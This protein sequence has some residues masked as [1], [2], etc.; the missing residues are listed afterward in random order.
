M[1]I[2]Q[3]PD[4]LINQI[5]AGE[6][7]ER[8]AS[9]VKELVENAL[10]AGATRVDI[11]LEEGGVRLIRIRDNGG[12]IP[13]DELP[14]AVSRHATS[15]IASLDD[16]ETVATL[17]FR[18]EALPS[19][20]S[21]SRFTLV[22]RRHDAEHGSAL[23]IEGGRLGEVTPRAHAPGTTVE[24]RELFYN[25]PARRK[26]L[27]AERT[28][29]GHIEEWLRSLA[30][31]RPDV[32]LRVSHN[33]KPSR[34]YKPGD[35]Y[36]DARL[37]E[38]LGEDFARQALRVD[39]GGAGLRL[40][41]WVAQPHYSRAS[42]DQQYL[43]VNGRSVRDRSVAHA[44]KM[45]Y[46]D[47][48]FHGRQPAYVLFL[49]LDPA[50][51]DVNVH[52]AK[53]EVRFREARLI[54]DFVYRTLQDALAHTRAGAMPNSIGTEG[55]S[56]TG[57]APSGMANTP[58]Y[59]GATGSG[60]G[61]GYGNWTPSQT[62]LGLRV[63]EARAAYSALYAPPSGSAQQQ[64]A[65]MQ[66][67]SGTGL[68]ATSHDSGVPPLG[69]AVAQLHGIY[70]LAENAEGLIVVDMH[71]A[72]ERIGYERLK[73]AHDSIGL[74][75][76]PLLVP[77]TLAVG[78]READTAEREADTLASLGF[79]ITRAG[80]QSLHVR[81]IPALL[82]NA[83]PEALLRDVL[84]D[85]REH[86]QSRRIATARDELLSTMA[87]HGAVRANRRLTVPE[88][89]ALLRDMEATERSGQCNH[90][91]PTWARVT[92]GEIDRWFLR[93]R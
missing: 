82:A 7:V 46:G 69:Y 66:T 26:F 40:H 58:N 23:E 47:V 9:V 37:G 80:P 75:A 29:L 72:H 19:I 34:R 65:A 41:G 22:S 86:G 52:P 56:D 44:V 6:V 89:N 54:H 64:S 5:A 81:S 84:G 36:S 30:L 76:Q 57:A 35:L 77:M 78:E 74:H 14:L 70:I 3:L 48:L 62:P 32:E 79:E 93:G 73:N 33:G 8:P 87:C 91:R 28:E 20:A 16:L 38:T 49:E 18:G 24:V 67:F 1:A 31:A 50:R 61:T 60:G 39:H 83:E 92:L 68:P 63:D 55:T 10:D 59:G 85:L 43:Y 51:V 27:R 17:G 13:P 21:V 2:R 88:M 12:G 90:G 25:V 53:H 15:K 71:A 42:T 4:I 45:A 11:E